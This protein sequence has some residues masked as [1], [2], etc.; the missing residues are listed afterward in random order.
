MEEI[1][2]KTKE[3][4]NM[5]E[6]NELRRKWEILKKAANILRVEDEDLL[7]VVERFLKEIK[8]MEKKIKP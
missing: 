4:K 2:E 3:E 7:R 5:K 6:F 1:E 8:E